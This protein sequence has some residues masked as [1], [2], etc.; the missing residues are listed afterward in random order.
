MKSGEHVE[1]AVERP[2]SAGLCWL[3][4]LSYLLKRDKAQFL[5]AL[6]FCIEHARGGRGRS[7]NTKYRV[8]RLELLFHFEES[9][10]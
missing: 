10:P 6:L 9:F 7:I 5:C 2:H 1:R 4:I 8:A 3:E